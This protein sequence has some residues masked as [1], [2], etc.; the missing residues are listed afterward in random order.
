MGEFLV[1]MPDW[2]A[3]QESPTLLHIGWWLHAKVNRTYKAN[4]WLM[5]SIC[6]NDLYIYIYVLLQI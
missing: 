5:K 4:K 3:G 1:G 6:G 2:Y